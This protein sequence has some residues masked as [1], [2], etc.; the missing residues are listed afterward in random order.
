VLDLASKDI[1]ISEIGGN[2]EIV[3]SILTRKDENQFDESN[4]L[5]KS[6]IVTESDRERR[7]YLVPVAGL[8]NF[9]EKAK[10][11]GIEVEHVFD[12]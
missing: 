9:I 7:V 12:Y 10:E 1:D 3:V 4:L 11:K 6:R 5:Y 8:L 2:D